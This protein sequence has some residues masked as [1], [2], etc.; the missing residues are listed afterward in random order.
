MFRTMSTTTNTIFRAL[1][2]FRFPGEASLR[3]QL[4]ALKILDLHLQSYRD[5][6]SPL[7]GTL[8][9]EDVRARF[10]MLTCMPQHG[11]EEH[12]NELLDT[13]I[14]LGHTDKARAKS[15]LA[16]IANDRQN[17]HNTHINQSVLDLCT[18]LCSAFSSI[19]LQ[20]TRVSDIVKELRAAPHWDEERNTKAIRVIQATEYTFTIG[21]TLRDVFVA[22]FLRV[23]RANKS[24]T[25]ELLGR[26]NQELSDMLY[27]CTTGHLARLV[28][29]LQGYDPDFTHDLN[30]SLKTK[31]FSVLNTALAG[32]TEVDTSDPA[33]IRA[34]V[35]EFTTTDAFQKSVGAVTKQVEQHVA[36]YLDG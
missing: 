13:A 24:N 22:V 33:S 20:T 12:A 30:A 25:L 34:F 36:A 31:I 26:F 6:R 18:R 17:V 29:V 7:V 1:D 28:N 4:D 15:D 5:R 10:M 32:S 35:L 2:V 21:R 16:S 3:K 27:M 9:L 11:G 8:T 23:T 19:E 14:A